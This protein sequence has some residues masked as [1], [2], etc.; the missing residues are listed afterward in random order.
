MK[1]HFYNLI[2]YN[3]FPCGFIVYIFK[4]IFFNYDYCSTN[5]DVWI[6]YLCSDRLHGSLW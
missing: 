1:V 2:T 5:K 4:Y 6:F 3:F